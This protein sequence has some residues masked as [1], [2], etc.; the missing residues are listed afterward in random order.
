M[1]FRLLKEAQELARGAGTLVIRSALSTVYREGKELAW[2]SDRVTLIGYVAFVRRD[3]RLTDLSPRV[4]GT[5]F[6]TV[7]TH[8]NQLPTGTGSVRTVRLL[9]QV[10]IV[11]HRSRAVQR[12]QLEIP[13]H[14]TQVPVPE[15]R[16]FAWSEL[17]VHQTGDSA[18]AGLTVC[19]LCHRSSTPSAPCA[20]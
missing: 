4:D 18:D 11:T 8:S 3:G 19:G 7:R 10:C 16:V 2:I 20:C 13:T 6:I 9:R 12:C 1:L 5:V 14:I 15:I 17:P